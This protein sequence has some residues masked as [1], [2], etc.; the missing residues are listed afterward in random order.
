MKTNLEKHFLCVVLILTF[1]GAVSRAATFT[2]DGGG[3]DG[4]WSTGA[5]WAGD[6]APSGSGHVLV[7]SGT[8]QL[9]TSNNGQLASIGGLSFG[10]SAGAF[11]L[12]G[13][14]LNLGGDI[15]NTSITTQTIGVS[16]QLTGHRTFNTQS[17]DLIVSGG[18]SADAAHRNL[19]KDGQGTLELRGVNTYAGPT[20]IYRGTLVLDA[21]TGSLESTSGISFGNP[22][23]LE[24]GNNAIFVVEDVDYTSTRSVT[25]ANYG[26]N[27]IRA[28]AIDLRLAGYTVSAQSTLTFDVSAPGSSLSFTTAP[29]TVGS[30]GRLAQT[31]ILDTTGKTGFASVDT[32]DGNKIV[33]L[34][35]QVD[36]ATNPATTTNTHALLVGSYNNTVADRNMNSLTLQGAGGGTVTGQN[37]RPREILMEEGTGDFVF[38]VQ[39]NPNVAS[40]QLFVHQYSTGTLTFASQLLATDAT[41]GFVKTG[42]GDVR[43]QA[44]SSSSFTGATRVQAGTLLLDGAF[45]KTA[46]VNVYEGAIL[47]GSGS[48]G[49]GSNPTAARVRAGG[50]LAGA[51][52]GALEITGTLTLDSESTY[53]FTLGSGADF[54]DVSGA[55]SLASGVTLQL[56]LAAPPIVDTPLYLIRSDS[57]ISGNFVYNGAVIGDGEVFSL[58]G[59]DFT[60]FQDAQSIWVQAVPEPSVALLCGLGAGLI[61]LR[62]GPRRRA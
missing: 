24:T 34:T 39:V 10:G 55:V 22:V 6:S 45:A 27:T 54:V 25:S 15:V 30:P 33:R 31:T 17:G 20:H 21:S 58:G 37:L 46:S 12:G 40:Y 18:I 32:L 41:G 7:F 59:Y 38:D 14:A 11:T 9:V 44:S 8:N 47:R 19:W 48:I 13:T 49:S 35:G 28:N 1:S 5:N 57:G 42:S 43:V 56:S 16:L 36:L 23:V 50:T 52:T 2:W 26:A 29:S 51:S 60:Y 4:N 3:G 53:A 61:F 62:R